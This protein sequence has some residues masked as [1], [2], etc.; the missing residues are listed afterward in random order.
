VGLTRQ[1]YLSRYFYKGK[2]RKIRNVF[3]LG[4]RVFPLTTKHKIYTRFVFL[5][6]VK[7]YILFVFWFCKLSYI[8][9]TLLMS[10]DTLL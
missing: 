2:E 6:E 1:L 9:V 4:K 3:S 5:G 8:D 10:V 7:F